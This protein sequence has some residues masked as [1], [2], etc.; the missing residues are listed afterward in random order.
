[1]TDAQLEESKEGRD[2]QKYGAELQS[3]SAE[4]QKETA[5]LSGELQ[6]YTSEIQSM[7]IDYQWLQGQMQTLKED[8]MRGI[9]ILVGGN[10]PPQPQQGAR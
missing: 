5:R 2:L 1:M 6:K 7:G 9:Q 4:I 10:T 8:Y 3:Y